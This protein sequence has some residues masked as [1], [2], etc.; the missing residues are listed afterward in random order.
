LKDLKLRKNIKNHGLKHV[1]TWGPYVYSHTLLFREIPHV[2]PD[3]YEHYKKIG[4]V[5][6]SYKRIVSAYFNR[7]LQIN[8]ESGTTNLAKINEERSFYWFVKNEI[9]NSDDI[10]YLS[11]YTNIKIDRYVKLKNLKELY[12]IYENFIGLSEE[13]LSIVKE[14]LEIKKEYLKKNYSF[15]K[16]LNFSDYDFSKDENELDILKNGVPSDNM[17]NEKNKAEIYEIYKDEIDFF[18]F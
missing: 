7:F 13:K 16:E 9:K 18:K 8:I 4:I 3:E 14:C 6:D 15:E 12:D 10:H 17:L 11:Q 2:L 1:K 5:R